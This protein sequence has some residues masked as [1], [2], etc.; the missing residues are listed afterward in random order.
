MNGVYLLKFKLLLSRDVN[1]FVLVVSVFLFFMVYFVI[2]DYLWR[3]G[4]YVL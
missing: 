1:D 2:V 4:E 3:I